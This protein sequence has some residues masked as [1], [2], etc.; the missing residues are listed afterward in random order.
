MAHTASRTRSLALAGTLVGLVLLAGCSAAAEPAPASPVAETDAAGPVDAGSSALVITC[1]QVA[2][3]AAPITAGMIFSPDDSSEDSSATSCVW[4]TDDVDQGTTDLE[5][6]GA[7]AIG[8]DGT[9][10]TADDMEMLSATGTV[11]D[12]PRAAAVDGRVY[13]L[14]EGE[15]LA[16]VGSVQLLFPEGTVTVVTTGAALSATAEETAVP[17]DDVIGVAADVAA[18]RR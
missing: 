4:I 18:L 6:Y 10:W 16:D 7:I 15:T 8:V 12:D 9:G 5:G 3:V 13:L 1:D 11:I 17:V 2:A 14:A